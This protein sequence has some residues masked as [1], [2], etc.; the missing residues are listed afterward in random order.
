MIA[1]AGAATARNRNYE[2]IA[3]LLQGLRRRPL[4]QQETA[5]WELLL[6]TR[7]RVDD[8]VL[9]NFPNH[10]ACRSAVQCTIRKRSPSAQCSHRVYKRMRLAYGVQAIGPKD[11]PDVL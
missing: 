6:E 5:K 3:Y 8:A 11:I 10:F 7:C 4:E 1:G 2:H 9:H